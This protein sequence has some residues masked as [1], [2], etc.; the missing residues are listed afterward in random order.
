MSQCL[1]SDIICNVLITDSSLIASWHVCSVITVDS[2][3]ITCVFVFFILILIFILVF[4][5]VDCITCSAVVGPVESNRKRDHY[6]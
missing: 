1:W 6:P 5:H 4:L 3:D 2:R